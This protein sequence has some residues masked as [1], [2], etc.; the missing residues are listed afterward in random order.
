MIKSPIPI[1]SRP[2]PTPGVKSLLHEYKQQTLILYFP[3]FTLY[4]SFYILIHSNTLQRALVYHS[5]V[6]RGPTEQVNILKPTS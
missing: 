2:I 1:P 5:K 4:I 3:D 6:L